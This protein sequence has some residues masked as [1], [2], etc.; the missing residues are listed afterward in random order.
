[1]AD[2]SFSN[3]VRKEICS[4][5]NDGDRRF[6]CLYGF[7]LFSR[8]ISDERICFQTESPISAELFGTLFRKIFHVEPEAVKKERRS[9]NILYSY[10]IR[11]SELISRVF[12]KYRIS[13]SERRIDP[14]LIATNSLGVFTAGIFMACGSVSDPSKDYHLE[15]TAPDETLAAQLSTL[16]GDI[17]VNAKTVVRRGQLIVY[18]KESESIEDVLTFIGAQSCTLELMNVKI[19]KDVRNK[20]NRIA[21]CDTANIDKV[22]KAADKQISDIKLIASVMGLDSLSDELREIAE[23]RL[24]NNDMSLQEIGEILS[25]PISRSGVNHRFK[26]LAKIADTLRGGG[27][28]HE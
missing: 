14:E 26:R 11:D 12:A 16:L 7:L 24:E 6:A 9:G 1:M 4:S 13:P 18:I 10:D 19:Y 23:I 8:I 27:D 28:K 25:S 22:L 21:N 20:A 5:I 3:E 2:I 17:G 15:F